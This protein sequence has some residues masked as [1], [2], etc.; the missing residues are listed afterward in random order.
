MSMTRYGWRRLAFLGFACFLA[1]YPA[2]SSAPAV[3]QT[4]AAPFQTGYR[5]DV[6]RRLVG[7]ISP[8]PNDGNP[9]YYPAERYT[10][11]DDGQLVQVETGALSAWQS[12]SVLPSAWTGYTIHKT[13]AYRYDVA[14]N[15]VEERVSAGGA[16]QTVTQMS[17][18]ADDRPLCSAVRMNLASIPAAGSNACVPG[19][20]GSAGSDR[21]T[22]T[23]YDSANQVLQIRRGVGTP[24]DQANVTYSY[25]LNGK[26]EYIVDANGNKARFAYDGMDRHRYWFFPSPDKPTAYDG[27]TPATALATAGDASA[28]D[29]ELYGY[30]ASSNRSSIRKRDGRSITFAHDAVNRM[31]IKNLPDTTAGDVYYSYDP[32]GLQLTAAFGS[33]TGEA[34]TN[35]Y[36]KAGRLSTSTNDV[37]GAS[38]T[39]TYRY[40]ANGN[41]TR[42]EYPDYDGTNNRFVLFEY[43]GL[44][45]MSAVRQGVASGTPPLTAS[46]VYN[47]K[48]ERACW[49]S[50]VVAACDTGTAN[51]TDYS[52]DALGRLASISFDLSGTAQDTTFCMGTM[53]GSNCTPSYNP[54]SQIGARTIS[55]DLYAVRRQYNAN[56]SYQV[57]G[58][59]QYKVAGNQT[60]GYDNNGNL[61]AFEGTSYGYDLENR[62]VSAAGTTSAVLTYDPMGRLN[63]TASAGVTTRFLYD[64]DALVGEYDGAGTMLRRYVHGPNTDEP[65][66]WYEGSSMTPRRILRADHQGSIVSVAESAGTSIAI[67]SYDEWGNPGPD[68]LGRFAYTGQIIIPE[69]GLYHYKARVYSPRLG[70]FL[71]TDPVGYDDQFNLYAYVANDPINKVDPTGLESPSYAL[72][73]RGP[74]LQEPSWERA[75]GALATTAVIVTA[76]ILPEALPLAALADLGETTLSGASGSAVSSAAKTDFVVTAKGTVIPKSQSAM[77]A[78]FKRAGISGRDLAGKGRQYQLPGSAGTRVRAMEPQAQGAGRRASFENARGQPVSPDGKPV[79]PPRNTQDTQRYVRDRT[80]VEQDK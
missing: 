27:S 51:R 20:A 24:L 42:L 56:R 78:G 26:K 53:S 39:L 38:R 66:L 33:L 19:T 68:N 16:V 49:Y 10:Y 45:R 61:T 44:D 65:I 13:I 35:S 55:N 79:Q 67:N 22:K 69:L 40:D 29:Y 25:T 76:A 7:K 47:N 43:D 54:A 77:E 9:T 12:Q 48:G 41:R 6:E 64:G 60:P 74:E 50:N 5:W 36:D 17:S 57:N 31:R 59:N 52:Y 14:G 2:L 11:N 62:L 3:A 73:G 71:Q 70:R 75:L 23:I 34:V 72:T 28:S 58:L 21:I 15:Q 18:D 4:G 32:R 80:H 63:S 1:A 30:D 46:F 37:G 8:F